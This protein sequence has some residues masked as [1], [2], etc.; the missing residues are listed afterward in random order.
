MGLTETREQIAGAVRALLL[1]T[2]IHAFGRNRANECTHEDVDGYTVI[3]GR[4]IHCKCG[5]SF[6]V[7]CMHTS[8][9]RLLPKVYHCNDCGENRGTGAR[10]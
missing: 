2:M 4:L 6:R 3:N 10:A 8:I 7:K 9:T 5:Q 1:S